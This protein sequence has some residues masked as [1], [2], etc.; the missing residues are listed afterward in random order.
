MT[1]A[2]PTVRRSTAAGPLTGIAPTPCPNCF[3]HGVEL[4][5]G[6]DN[7]PVH[8]TLNMPTPEA[9]VSYPRGNLKLGFCPSCG[10]VSNTVFDGSVHEYSDKCEESQGFSPTFNS[11]AKKLA[12]RWI[13]RYNL[14]NKHI[15]EIGCGKGE[16][17]MLMCELGKNR[18]TGIDPSYQ[19]DR[20]PNKKLPP[21][22]N[23]IQDLYSE[24]YSHLETDCIMC[25]HTLEHIG[26][27]GEFL[28]SIR[29]TIGNR[30]DTLV[31]F[32][33]PDVARV[34]KEGAF[35][36]I[37]YEHC[38]Y[39]SPGSLARLFRQS[40][41]E[42]TELERDYGDQ[43]L[44]IGA[45]PIE[46]TS[47]QPPLKLERDLD[48][49]AADVAKFRN[50]IGH[51]LDGWRKTIREIV[52]CGQRVVLWGSLSKGT[53]FLTTLKLGE[54][55]EYVVDINPHRQNKYMPGTG[56][57]I[58]GPAFLAEYQ[59]THIVVMNP[60]YCKEIQK[61]LDKLGVKAE[62]LPVGV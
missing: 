32:E 30:L 48:E 39:F 23:F 34:L 49:T 45:K 56:Q 7:I 11:F 18:G 40:G 22:V 35:W 4:F 24:K 31:L 8:S 1:T 36:D 51:T 19:P 50:S 9:A 47:N 46:G 5:Y 59:P 41:F 43:Y 33:L 26:P 37:Y 3:K 42:L 62:L 38:S 55:I 2:S 52:S 17:L 25:R 60:I 61:D 53:A 12:Q 20:N 57:K 27:T 28:R 15:L 10:F 58:V 16:F 44:L 54:E 13:D 6:V 29:A 14:R 21:G